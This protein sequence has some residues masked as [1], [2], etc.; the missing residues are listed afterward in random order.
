MLSQQIIM[1][2]ILGNK[3][4]STELMFGL[5]C[6]GMLCTLYLTGTENGPQLKVTSQSVASRMYTACTLEMQ[7]LSPLIQDM[8]K[9]MH[10]TLQL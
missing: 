10:D 6:I 4:I 2:G 9:A 5:W 7:L 3:A 8:C 1:C